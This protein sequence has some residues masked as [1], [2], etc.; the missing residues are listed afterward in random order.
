MRVRKDWM[1]RVM[2]WVIVLGT[3]QWTCWAECE[4]DDSSAEGIRRLGKYALLPPPASLTEGD[5][6][7]LYEKAIKTLPPD[8]DWGQI[9][10][11]LALPTAQLPLQQVQGML[12]QP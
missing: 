4:A 7:P 2:A 1:T 12:E 9:H 10:D 5:A 6:V 3:A 11:W 8:T